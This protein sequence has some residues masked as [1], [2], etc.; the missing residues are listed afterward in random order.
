MWAGIPGI[1]NTCLASDA[2]SETLILLSLLVCLLRWKWQGW[3][4]GA[5]YFELNSAWMGWGLLWCEVLLC[6]KARKKQGGKDKSQVV[7]TELEATV[8]LQ[9]LLKN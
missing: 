6:M 4:F 7:Q 8:P 2:S 5:E 1:E 3:V 9:V